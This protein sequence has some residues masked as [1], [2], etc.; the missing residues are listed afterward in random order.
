MITALQVFCR[1][2]IYV[3]I[4]DRFQI[5]FVFIFFFYHH[6]FLFVLFSTNKINNNS[7]AFDFGHVINIDKRARLLR[8][9]TNLK[10]CLDLI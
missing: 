1:Y 4:I 7:D 9:I 8:R 10:Y 2:I 5:F 3:N 6:I